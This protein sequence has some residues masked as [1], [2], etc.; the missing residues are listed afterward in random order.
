MG[1]MIRGS[2]M[3]PGTDRILALYFA[4]NYVKFLSKGI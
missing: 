4:L 3:F 1:E 2:V